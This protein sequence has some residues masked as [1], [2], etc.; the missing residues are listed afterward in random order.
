[1]NSRQRA[2][3]VAGFLSGASQASTA[4]QVLE[5]GPTDSTFFHR[6]FA[7][8]ARSIAEAEALELRRAELDSGLSPQTAIERTRQL[9]G[10]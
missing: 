10:R 5:P 6:G 1:M 4:A 7:A 9:R 3:F 8:G 2:S